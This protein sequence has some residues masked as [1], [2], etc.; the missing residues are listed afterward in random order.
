MV[1]VVS[2]EIYPGRII[3]HGNRIASV[4]RISDPV[5]GYI[6]PGL[7]DAHVH[8]ESS[9]LTPGEFARLAIKN[10]TTQCVSDPHEIANVLGAEG[11]RFMIAD[12]ARSPLK[13]KFGVPSCVPATSCETSGAIIGVK[14]VGEL[15]DWEGTGYLSEVMN[16]PAVILHDREVMDKIFQAQK[17]DMVID[18]HAP[19]ITG[20]DLER[21]IS[22]GISTDHECSTLEEAQEKIEKG[23]KILIRE[24]SAAKNLDA[25]FPLVDYFPE[26]VMFCTDDIHPDDL[27]KGHMNRILKRAVINGCDFFNVLRA[28][29]INPMKHY[30][31][32]RALL[33]PGDT[34]DFIRVN[35]LEEMEVGE[36]YING[37]KV[38]DRNEKEDVVL[39]RRSESPNL[40]KARKL[41]DK[42][43][44]VPARGKNIRVIVAH[45]G[46]LI[47]GQEIVKANIQENLVKCRVDQDVLKIVVL[48]RYKKAKPAI[49]FI[50]G[51][52]LRKGAI[53]SSIAHDSHNIICVGVDDH[54]MT[55]AINFIVVHKGGMV[56]YD[57]HT[58]TGLALPVAGIM[59]DESG[60]EVAGQYR[61]LNRM[62]RDLGSGLTAPFMTLSFMA[63]L[64][65]PELK[66]SDK[67]IFDVNA[68]RLTSLFA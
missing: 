12:A 17:R 63:L 34:A 29:T 42:D 38:Y 5:A 53:A 40:F 68:F 15:L 31:L 14:Q 46:E 6:M 61:A 60:E 33:Q 50:K 67:G 26:M 30:S 64:V 35:S 7:V 51:F 16:F 9:M 55:E 36:T 21:Y 18:G 62:A 56:I 20:K 58:L 13:I 4:E 28:M 59:T 45:D 41:Q 52:G 25:L 10:G 11:V 43:I 49:G 27:D 22:A 23:M 54:E 57:G 37:C 44:E 66:L 2:G 8:I 24:G 19:G 39:A 32:E 48:N 1:D 65:I 47:T 3:L